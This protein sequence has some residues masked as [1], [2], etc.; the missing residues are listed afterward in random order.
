[1]YI[2]AKCKLAINDKYQ[3][4][5]TRRTN[6]IIDWNGLDKFFDTVHNVLDR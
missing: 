1:M 4:F 3:P 2:V 6:W 5:S